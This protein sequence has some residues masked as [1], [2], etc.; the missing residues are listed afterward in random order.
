MQYVCLPML[1]ISVSYI[2]ILIKVKFKRGI[3][4]QASREDGKFVIMAFVIVVAFLLCWT[5]F[6]VTSLLWIYYCKGIPCNFLTVL[7]P[8]GKCMHYFN[9]C[10]NPL[11]YAALNTKFRAAFQDIIKKCIRRCKINFMSESALYQ[12]SSELSGARVTTTNQI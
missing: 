7:V 8:V 1:I 5:P 11:I 6:F 9:S 2:C 12:V 4:Y 10:C 3:A